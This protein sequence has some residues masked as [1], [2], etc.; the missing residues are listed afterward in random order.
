MRTK[1]INGK[2]HILI[3]G[4]KGFKIYSSD[5]DGWVIVKGKKIIETSAKI[6]NEYITLAYRNNPEEIKKEFNRYLNNL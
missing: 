6:V 3:A 1:T 5:K 4:G 2:E